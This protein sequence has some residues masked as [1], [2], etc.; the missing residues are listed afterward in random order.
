M[1]DKEQFDE[2][3]ISILRQIEIF[4]NG[5]QQYIEEEEEHEDSD[6]SFEEEINPIQRK[7]N[8]KKTVD[9]S[10]INEIFAKVVGKTLSNENY[11]NFFKILQQLCLIPSN[12][13]GTKVWNILN[14]SLQDITGVKQGFFL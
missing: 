9:F 14:A 2:K 12:E 4:E 10:D 6:D 11:E 13:Q 3:L 1:D 8:K 5:F 7:A